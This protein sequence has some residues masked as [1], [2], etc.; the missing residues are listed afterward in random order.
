MAQTVKN[1]SAMQEI[2]FKGSVNIIIN[3]PRSHHG[4]LAHI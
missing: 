1:L 3:V 4:N 2:S